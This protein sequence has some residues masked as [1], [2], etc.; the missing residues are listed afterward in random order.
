MIGNTLK[1]IREKKNFSA[2]EIAWNIVSSAQLSRIENKNQIPATDSFIKMLYRLNVS[3]EEFCLLSN[4]EHVK[5]RIETK[6]NMDVILRIKNRQQIE[7]SIDKMK[8]YYKIYGDPYFNH[9]R[10]LLKAT[11][12]LIK[13]KN[14]YSK[15][16]TALI[17]ISDYLSSVETW[18]E[19]EI[20]LFSNC[21][22]LYPLEKA[23]KIG[24]D[25]LK[26]I[27]KIYPLDKADE[28]TSKLLLN[29]AIYSLSD[30]AYYAHAHRYADTV[31]TLPRSKNIL[32]YPLLAKLVKQVAYHKLKSSKYDEDYLAS[33]LSVLKLMEFDDTYEEFASLLVLHD[34][35][36]SCI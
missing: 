30:E 24:D 6:K 12:I 27:K 29:L 23:V 1:Y 15:T 16:L 5:V 13:T 36:L 31:L 32:Y 11:L 10:C 33:L 17:P 18:L 3:F 7:T 8:N 34:V 28:P 14:D 19:Y 22:Y 2:K 25:S 35:K 20:D 21:I 4:N 26:N 9:M